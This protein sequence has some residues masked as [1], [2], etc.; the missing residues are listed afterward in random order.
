MMNMCFV[1]FWFILN[2][3]DRYPGDDYQLCPKYVAAL[4]NKHSGVAWTIY[5]FGTEVFTAQPEEFYQFSWRSIGTSLS[6]EYEDGYADTGFSWRSSVHP[7][8]IWVIMYI[9]KIRDDRLWVY[10]I[11]PYTVKDNPPKFQRV[12]S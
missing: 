7:R 6:N 5:R 2:F 3:Y 12:F 10:V 1:A 4:W 8:K 11:Y 9:N